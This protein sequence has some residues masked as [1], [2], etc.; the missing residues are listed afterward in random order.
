MLADATSSSFLDGRRPQTK[1][2]VPQEPTNSRTKTLPTTFSNVV[3]FSALGSAYSK[4]RRQDCFQPPVPR[5]TEHPC[6]ASSSYALPPLEHTPG[7]PSFLLQVTHLGPS[8][9][10]LWV[11]TS[12]STGK[13]SAG[14]RL[15][16]DW[17]CG[18]PGPSVRSLP[19]LPPSPFSSLF[20]LNPREIG[21]GRTRQLIFLLRLFGSM[22]GGQTG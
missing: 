11:G 21:T 15:G 20:P 10:L 13:P 12:N 6:M 14:V 5:T 19:C 9:S 1:G 22:L 18:M 3:A 2:R 7:A 4:D 8:S 17:V 16:G